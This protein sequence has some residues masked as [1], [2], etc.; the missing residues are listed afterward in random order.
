MMTVITM[1]MNGYGRLKEPRPV[2][3]PL[4]QESTQEMQQH[5]S[6]GKKS[7]LKETPHLDV[8]IVALVL[9]EVRNL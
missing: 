8:S 2:F 7:G 4:T 6:R 9:S 1:M 5:K 3:L